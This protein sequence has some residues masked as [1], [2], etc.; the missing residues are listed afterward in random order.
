MFL[1]FRQSFFIGIVCL[2]GFYASSQARPV[3]KQAL[4]D[5]FGPFLAKK[6][7]DCRTCHLPDQSEYANSALVSEKPHNAFG[8]RLKEVKKELRHAGKKIDIP[9][10]LEA[11]AQEDCDGD[12][13]SNLI[14]LLTGHFPGDPNDKP[15]PA[16]IAEF[17][18]I[19]EAFH[20]FQSGY[21][22]RPFEVVKRPP[23]PTVE[24][25]DWVRNPIDAFIA[26]EHEE[27]GL[28]PRPEAPKEV[29]LR[30]VYLD[31]IGLPPTPA[32]LHAFLQDAATD[33]YEKV[34]AQLL[35][36]PQYGERW[37]RHWMDVWRYSDWAGYG[38]Q[39]RD[40]QPHIWRWRDWIIE[41]LNYDKPYDRMILEM[42]AGDELAPEDPDA[43]R[44]TGYLVRNYKLLS[45]ETWMQ[46]TVDHIG[47]GFLGVTL[48]CARCHD[49]MF[50]AI[51]Q[52][53]YYQIRAVFEPYQVR[54][55][56]LPGKPDI[57]LDGLVHAYDANP[58]APTF[59]YIRGDERTP[60]K[61][62]V[63]P[64]VP[65]A[66]GGTF[67]EIKLVDLPVSSFAPDK[68][69]FVI[70]ETKAASAST[71]A[72]ARKT[73]AESS[74]RLGTALVQHINCGG[75]DALPRLSIMQEALDSWKVAERDV[76]LAVTKHAAL[77]W[78]LRAEEL[79][80]AGNK[81]SAAWKAAATE[82]ASLQRQAAVLEGQR[83]LEIARRAN[84]TV[85]AKNKM[86]TAKKVAEAKQAL[87][88]AQ[89]DARLSA[90]TTYTHRPMA[91]Y[92]KTSTGRRLAL[93]R[94]IAAKENPLTAR[95]AVNHI[96]LRHF[97]QGIVPSVFD[98]GRNGRPP[99][100]PALLDWLAAEFMSPSVYAQEKGG[101]NM[102]AIHRLIVTS[103]T[104]RMAST[105]DAANLARDLD[106]RFLWRFS[107]RRVEAEV[108]RDAVFFVAGLLDL[109]MGGPDIEHQKG[110]TVPRRSIY[111]QH[112]SEK[113]MKFLKLFDV[114]AV[115]ECYQRKECI[116][117]QQA[118]AMANSELTRNGSRFLASTLAEEVPE[119]DSAAYVQAAFEHVLTRPPTADE[120][121]ECVAFLKQ[122]TQKYGDQDPRGVAGTNA[123]VSKPPVIPQLRAREDLLHVLFNHHDFVTLR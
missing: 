25:N 28:A 61:A 87:A 63:I 107:P 45:R 56:R 46:E 44:A 82:A 93:A 14:E 86:E 26:M 62:P 51:L 35:H 9:T 70:G 36:S 74:R 38:A 91:T 16:E 75:W 79:E 17:P 64:G 96:W 71:I 18:K 115:T 99:S 4:A 100:H 101:W 11:I 123:N 111:F 12:G 114:A 116:V 3:H 92:P 105:P 68:R 80:D 39:V 59:L 95:V 121:A 41:S 50:D 73:F 40:S 43:L 24:N 13:V 103:N 32:A 117:P 6:L 98:F 65:E 85:P 89:A 1:R 58:Q 102:K 42:L 69:S 88:K 7:N 10:R 52:K 94:W 66:L 108:V 22:W 60:D 90:T 119:K 77:L 110:L 31:L 21:P 27:H 120:L 97:G 2:F 15:A 33:A 37:G 8:A 49:H 48:G 55:D 106:N 104:Y 20:K 122:Q 109:S 84:R 30:R 23:I 113:Q 118:L 67:P 78:V 53:E 29:L 72:M 76:A 47:Q 57:K 81:E 19:L 34:V 83:N 54:T 5:Y 112:A